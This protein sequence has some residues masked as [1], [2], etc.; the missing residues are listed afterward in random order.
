MKAPRL[1]YKINNFILK[2]SILNHRLLNKIDFKIIKRFIKVS[3]IKNN[4][5]IIINI[6]N[7]KFSL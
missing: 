6:N 7:K 4:N 3:F 5:N 1:S 2:N